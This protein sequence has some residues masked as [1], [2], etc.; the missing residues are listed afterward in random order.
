M[1]GIYYETPYIVRANNVSF[2]LNFKATAATAR[3]AIYATA[4]FTRKHFGLCGLLM[5]LLFGVDLRSMYHVDAYSTR[6]MRNHVLLLSLKCNKIQDLPS[7]AT[8][9][10]YCKNIR[11]S[12]RAS[13]K[14]TGDSRDAAC[15]S[16]QTRARALA[17][18]R[19]H[20]HTHTHT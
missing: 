11:A 5:C 1:Y 17:R 10:C 20:T 13:N 15:I 14:A 19:A 16:T 6:R 8:V 7:E 3:K 12:W 2:G 18:A 4:K 9:S